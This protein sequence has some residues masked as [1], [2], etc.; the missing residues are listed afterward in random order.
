M[1]RHDLFDCGALYIDANR[2]NLAQKEVLQEDALEAC[3]IVRLVMTMEVW[4][5]QPR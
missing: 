2:F 4:R 3:S 5:D 1:L